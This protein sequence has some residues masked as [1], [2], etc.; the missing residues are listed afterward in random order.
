MT[1]RALILVERHLDSFII[2]TRLTYPQF[3]LRDIV[4]L[5]RPENQRSIMDSD[6]NKSSL[7]LPTLV[8][9]S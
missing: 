8:R 2:S 3:R 1:L 9:L 7:G 4:F 5:P 6:S